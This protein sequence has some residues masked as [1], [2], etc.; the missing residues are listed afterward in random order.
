MSIKN[1]ATIKKKPVK[2]ISVTKKVTVKL[3]TKKK[4]SVTPFK[5]H[6]SSL[7]A[8][9]KAPY[10]EGKTQSG[11][12]ITSTSFPKKTIILYFYPKD[13]TATCTKQSCN[14]RDEYTFLNNKNYV[15]IGVSADD[16]KSHA[17]FAKKY[18]LPF[19]LI[20]DTE[21]KIISD[22]DVWGTKMLAGRIYDGIVRTTFIIDAK[23]I[24]KTIITKVNS[25]NHA[26]QI[27]DLNT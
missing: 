4:P 2:K 16:E 23:G 6:T 24:I 25:G 9:Q 7:K 20:A 26:Q 11:E 21:K 10:F 8:G 1:T 5:A 12:T 27:V 13:D 15:V 19:P 18:S 14:L 3:V 22:F 17:K